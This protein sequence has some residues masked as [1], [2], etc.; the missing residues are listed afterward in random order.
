[1]QQVLFHVPEKIAGI[2][3]FGFGWLLVAW[4]VF[5]AGWLLLLARRNGWSQ[6]T[7][8]HLPMMILIAAVIALILPRLQSTAP[9]GAVLG[10]PIRGYGVMM[11]LGMVAGVGLSVYQARR[12]GIR[13]EFV[14]SLAMFMVIAGIVGARAFFVIQKW[15]TFQRE[16]WWAT[17]V[18]VLKFTEG[19]L[20]V[21]GSVIGGLLA[22][23]IYI[24]WNGFS[25]LRV[26]DL[27]APG[28]LLGLALGR[29]GC[30]LNG[31]CWGGAC[32]YEILAIRFPQASPAYMD[33]VQS[34]ILLGLEL[35]PDP[36]DPEATATGGPWLVLG[37][38]PHSPAAEQGLRAG[39]HVRRMYVQPTDVWK[40]ARR[41]DDRATAMVTVVMDDGGVANWG[42]RDL[43]QGAMPL[44]PTQIYSSINAL[45]LCLLLWSFY[46]FR[47]REGEVFALMLSVYPVSRFL[48]EQI[49]SDESG[50]WGTSLTISQ[51]VSLGILILAVALW[52]YVSR[53][54][55]NEL[56]GDGVKGVKDN[57]AAGDAVS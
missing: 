56:Q 34:G 30:L 8:G 45:L 25:L 2:S 57:T 47:R 31:C 10:L 4:C 55:R 39:G 24:R 48:L 5:C 50:Q 35:V 28:M 22:A 41:N 36:R 54:P 42:W 38:R 46:P 18:E 15:P 23:V 20:V 32:D 14:V 53:Q 1:M 7:L 17:I 52:I 11:L 6:E 49:R 51:W 44:H 37:I 27:I 19:G 43:P 16:T 26:G 29:I 9:S 13:P 33:Q 40:E 21:Y 12:E 3:V